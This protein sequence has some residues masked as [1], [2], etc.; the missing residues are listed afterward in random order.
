MS[1]EERN[2]AESTW[3]KSADISDKHYI[4]K[5]SRPL[6]MLHVLDVWDKEKDKEKQSLPTESS[7]VAWGIAFPSSK[8]ETTE[9]TYVV[10]TTWWAEN[11]GTPEDG[12]DADDD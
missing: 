12:S 2:A 11:Y 9:V 10:N 1:V 7:V 4:G 5:R 3:N 6:L 8:Y